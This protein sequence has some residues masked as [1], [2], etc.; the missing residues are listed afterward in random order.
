MR[1]FTALSLLASFAALVTVSGCAAAIPPQDLVTARAEYDR[2]SHGP[3]AQ[4]DPADLH[5]A[6]ETLDNAEKSFSDNGDS[7]DVRD[8]A[9]AADRRAQIAESRARTMQSEQQKQAVLDQMAANQAATVRNT[10]AALGQANQIVALQGQ[11]LVDERARREEADRRA[12]KAME[13]L[14]RL[15][16]VKK[17][18]R[19]L[20]LTLSGSVLFASAKSD[21]LPDATGK[22]NEVAKVLSEQDPNAKIL[23]EGYTDSQGGASYNMDLSQRRADSVRSYMVSHGVAS[24]RVTAQ[25]FGLNSPIA[26]NNSPEGRANNRRVE[27]VVSPSTATPTTSLK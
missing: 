13:E 6:R 10:S 2:A 17:E 4:L 15:G 12:A 8:Y 21:L 16:S 5:E 9:Y 27:I 19:G 18:T 14:A 26:D 25:G 22:L 20:V 7:P 1:N 23:I 24:D 11:A 3:A